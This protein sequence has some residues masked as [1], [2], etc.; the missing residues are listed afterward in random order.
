MKCPVCNTDLIGG[1]VICRTHSAPTL[2]PHTPDDNEWQ[3]TKKLLFGSKEMIKTN[4]LDEGWYCPACKKVLVL[5]SWQD[6]PFD[7]TSGTEH[8]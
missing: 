7:L 2:H 6:D 1:E 8:K 5:W 4:H 3:K